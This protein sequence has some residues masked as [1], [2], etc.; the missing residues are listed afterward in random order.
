MTSPLPDAE[1]MFFD[2]LLAFDHLRHQIHIVA[3]AD[4]S[5][6]NPRRA[7]DRA[8][9]DIAALERKLAEGLSPALWRKSAKVKAGKLKVHAGTRRDDY[10]R[11]VER[12]KEYIAAGDIFQV[13]YSQ[14]FDFTP[15]VAPFDLV[16]RSAPGQ[17]VALSLFPEDG[18]HAYSRVISRDAG[19]RYGPQAGVP[20]DRGHASPRSR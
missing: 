8:L 9:R 12:C 11:N 20:A 10:L 4:V 18:G 1:L 2:R 13:V 6:E 19:A 14:R 5:R 16:P 3:A 7:Y 17:S 15:E